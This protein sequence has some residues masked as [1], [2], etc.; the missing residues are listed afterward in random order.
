MTLIRSIQRIVGLLVLALSVA[1]ASARGHLKLQSSSPAHGDTIRTPLSEIRLTFTQ[2]VDQR[3]TTITLIDPS[4]GR[5]IDAGAM[6][7]AIGNSPTKEY[8]LRLSQPLVSGY[9]TVKWRTV[10]ADGHAITGMFD[11]VADAG[12]KP[13]LPPS[14]PGG[15]HPDEHGGHHATEIPAMFNPE[16]SLLWIAA[17]WLNFLGLVLM[18]GA[19]AFEFFVLN[20][21]RVTLGDDSAS[22]IDTRTRNV[23]IIAAVVTLLSNGLRLWLQSGSIHGAERLWEAGLLRAILLEMGWGRAWIA[24]TVATLGVLISAAIKTDDRLDSWFSAAPLAVIA[25]AMPAFSGHAAAVQQMA[26]VPIVDDAVH[27]IAASAWLG[28][29]AVLLF[30]ALPVVFRAELG[31]VKAAALVNIF[32]PVALV[33]ASVTMFTGTLN[34]F[35]QIEAFSDL[36]NTTYGRVLAIKLGLVIITATI[37]A[38]NWKVVKPRLGTEAATAHIKRSA[39]SEVMVGALI[40]LITA[41]LVATP[42]N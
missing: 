6:I 8:T 39:M 28:T 11:F 23:A 16:T 21:A 29:L 31:F 20:R 18:V 36:W 32:S 12:P 17:R 30:A 25:A 34:A 27:V 24:Q 26:I 33:M 19:V 5:E 35:I 40:I 10:G 13:A 15:V 2:A 1:P 41:L 4:T 14:P 22:L 42:T 7:H 3:F 9:F 37:G 38:Y